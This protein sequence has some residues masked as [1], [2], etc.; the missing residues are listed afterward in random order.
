MPSK[1]GRTTEFDMSVAVLR[2]LNAQPN[3][4]AG[5]NELR[6]AIPNHI[7]LTVGDMEFST[8]RPGERLWEQLLR[9]IQSHKKTST[10]F[11]RLGYLEHV[12]GGGYRITEKGRDFV[13]DQDLE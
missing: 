4:V 2:H 11:I 8:T 10:N 13:K 9:N 5:L 3:G 6:A 12:P 1:V 7:M